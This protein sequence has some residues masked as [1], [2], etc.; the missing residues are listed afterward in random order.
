MV[1]TQQNVF[2]IIFSRRQYC[3]VHGLANIFRVYCLLFIDQRSIT[4]AILR[5]FIKFKFVYQYII[6]V[7]LSQFQDNRWSTSYNVFFVLFIDQR[8]ITIV[9]EDIFIKIKIMCWWK[10]ICTPQGKWYS[11]KIIKI[12]NYSKYKN[13]QQL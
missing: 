6:Q 7:Y 9:T 1:V 12:K 2:L 5:I 13:R 8:S 4:I 11:T 10:Q 3:D